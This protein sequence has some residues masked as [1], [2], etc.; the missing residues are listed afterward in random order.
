MRPSPE[1][2]LPHMLELVSA[3][4]SQAP[5]A[6]GRWRALWD[7]LLRP[8]R[9]DS[10]P[11]VAGARVEGQGQVL[12]VPGPL[13]LPALRLEGAGRGGRLFNRA[14]AQLAG[15]VSRIVGQALVAQRARELGAREERQRIADDLHDDRGARLLSLAQSSESPTAARLAREAIDEMRLALRGLTGR[16]VPLEQWLA[17]WRAETV[18][19]ADAAGLCCQWRDRVAAP[20]AGALLP[21]APA[22]QLA[23]VLR[24]AVSNVLRH[25]Q[26]NALWV[27]WQVDG[28]AL[29]LTVEDNGR[30]LAAEPAPVAALPGG[31]GLP[32]MQRRM[33]RLGGTVVIERRVE[34]GT[35]V[36]ARMPLLTW[37]TDAQRADR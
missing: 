27:D 31:H 18:A 26:A 21:A 34:G 35:R 22:L 25:A 7:E 1:A 5:D 37:A 2:L 24:E 17:D 16:P 33:T 11:A 29:V 19:R 23:R 10:V 20:L 9:I 32:G 14:D 4:G 6:G 13:D 3:A 15:Q 36:Q 28:G 12:I 8:A 30:G